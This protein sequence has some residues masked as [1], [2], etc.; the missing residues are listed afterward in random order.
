MFRKIKD[1]LPNSASFSP[2]SGRE[3]RV[4][5][6]PKQKNNPVGIQKHAYE[7]IIYSLKVVGILYD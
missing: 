7:A 4:C 2:R 1:G 3:S 5:H 6:A